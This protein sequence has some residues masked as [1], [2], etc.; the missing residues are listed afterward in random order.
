MGFRHPKAERVLTPEE[1]DEAM[2]EQQRLEDLYKKQKDLCSCGNVKWKRSSCCSSCAEKRLQ[3]RNQER[4]KKAFQ[5]PRCKKQ[6]DPRVLLCPECADGK[7]IPSGRSERKH[8]EAMT[9]M[10]YPTHFDPPQSKKDD[11]S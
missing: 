1:E 6:K 9:T 7:E 2:E 3:E 5:C 8:Q 11:L 4:S 10:V